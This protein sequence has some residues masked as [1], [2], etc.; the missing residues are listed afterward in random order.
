MLNFFNL[1]T[2]QNIVL[3]L[4]SECVALPEVV[5][6]WKVMVSGSF[7]RIPARL[8]FFPLTLC[9]F[10]WLKPCNQLAVYVLHIGYLNFMFTCY[11]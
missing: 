11:C 3:E 2:I 7:N 10:D 9:S 4:I 5:I 8:V 1:T 6:I